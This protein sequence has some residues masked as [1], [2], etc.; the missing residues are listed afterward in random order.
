MLPRNYCCFTLS[1]LR[2][3]YTTKLSRLNPFKM[4]GGGFPVSSPKTS[5]RWTR[6]E[7]SS[8]FV[9]FSMREEIMDH[10]SPPSYSPLSTVGWLNSWLPDEPDILE[11][12]N[13]ST[14]W[15]WFHSTAP[16][17]IPLRI[18]HWKADRSRW[19]HIRTHSF[20]HDYTNYHS[21]L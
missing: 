16:I 21:P 4:L 5:P 17:P 1:N 8:R 9:R 13:Y 19:Y 12:G 20:A 7:I 15:I 2:L 18:R 6:S 10:I 11:C 14:F 3:N